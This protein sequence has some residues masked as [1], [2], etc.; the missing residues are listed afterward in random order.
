MTQAFDD[1]MGGG[2]SLSFQF[3]APG[4]SVTGIITKMEQVAQTDM[5]T[6]QPKFFP[7]GQPKLMW[8]VTLQTT[9]RNGEGLKDWDP[10][11]E[12]DSGE[13]M[14]YLKWKSEDA[15]KQAVKAS[16]AR[17]P[18]LGGTLTLTYTKVGPKQGNFNTKLWGAQYRP[19]APG[20]AFMGETYRDAQGSDHP[21]AAAQ[22]HQQEE[23]WARTGRPGGGYGPP[24]ANP[25]QPA[26]ATQ[27]Q[28]SS[29]L[30]AIQ[31]QQQADVP[32]F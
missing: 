4:D 8:A 23:N 12:E 5:D 31:R 15:V 2:R 19:P 6:G 17:A 14:V 13:R 3:Y 1:F 20:A 21:V 30:D 7:N 28:P 27:R 32:P 24:P 29:T 16:G 26:W 22:P 9:F 18:E 10:Q 11:N 25:G